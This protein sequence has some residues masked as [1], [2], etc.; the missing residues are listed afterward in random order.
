ME[1]NWNTKLGGKSV[2]TELSERERYLTRCS[3]HLLCKVCPS[4]RANG[5]IKFRILRRIEERYPPPRASFA[6]IREE[7]G[8]IFTDLLPDYRSIRGRFF[9]SGFE[10]ARC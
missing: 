6:V 1:R 2:D 7:R 3:R 5:G 8:S 10:I 4:P 9:P